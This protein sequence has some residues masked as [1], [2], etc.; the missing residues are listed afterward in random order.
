MLLFE[1]RKEITPILARSLGILAA[2]FPYAEIGSSRM[3]RLRTTLC[4]ISDLRIWG[5]NR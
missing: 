2:G 4:P 5:G 1:E 3:N